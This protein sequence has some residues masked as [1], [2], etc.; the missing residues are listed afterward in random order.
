MVFSSLGAILRLVASFARSTVSAT[1][2]DLSSDTV[3]TLDDDAS[4][5]AI[6]REV[7]KACGCHNVLSTGDGRV[8]LQMLRQHRVRLAICDMHMDPM[9]GLTFLRAARSDPVGRDMATIMLTANK[10]PAGAAALAPLRIGAWLFKPIS[11]TKLMEGI[12]SVLDAPLALNAPDEVVARNIEAIGRR[13]GAQL[14][15]D[16]T[17]MESAMAELHDN[18]AAQRQSWD[19]MRKILHSVKGQAGTF[20][21]ALVTALAS[22]G[23]DI[24]DD[25]LALTPAKEDDIEVKRALHA[26]VTAMRMLA[27]GRMLG[28]GGDAGANLLEKL[29][30]FI[31]PMCRRLRGKLPT[32]GGVAE[33]VPVHD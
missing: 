7:L 19:A 11:A 17:K 3:L 8:A 33:P 4:M 18:P 10:P 30:A 12:S 26:I 24:L 32:P 13:Y 28:D 27:R 20:G 31:L 23:Q 9:D 6:I 5:R 21:Y 14:D 2:I 16:I 15:D 22:R 29:D 25:A 1:K